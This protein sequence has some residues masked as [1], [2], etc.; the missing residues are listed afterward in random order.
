MS[1]A[2]SAMAGQN[3]QHLLLTRRPS[4]EPV[5]GDFALVDAAMPTPGEGQ[6]LLRNLY[7]SIDPYLRG[8]MKAGGNGYS[9]AFPL[10]EPV[11]GATLAEVVES[12]VD[13]F[14]PGDR[15]VSAT[16]W[17]RFALSDGSDLRRVPTDLA[18]PTHALGALGMTGFTA[19]Y[20]LTAIGRPAAGETVVV[21]AASGAVGAVVGQVAAIKGCRV[22]GIVGGPEKVRYLTDEL[23]FAAAIDHRAPDLAGRLAAAV[24]DGIDIYFENVGGAV[25]DAVWPHMNVHARVPVCGLVAGYNATEAPA[26][27]DRLP[28]V[29]MDL[30]TKRI[31]MQGFLNGEHAEKHFAAFEAEVG[32]WLK[33][34]KLHAREDVLDGLE[35]APE[36]LRR[37]LSGRNF[38]K[39]LVRV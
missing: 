20:G 10:D 1:A 30:I 18:T 13:G 39:M 8:R 33:V 2:A 22:V 15:V 26:G 38:G 21:S 19:W 14:R 29:A 37:V 16:G 4:G 34:G 36:A 35:Q 32:E 17:R 3:N 9:E 12:R 23:G 27:P 7:L 28:G 6:V 31:L 24:P 5:E 25:F 11:V